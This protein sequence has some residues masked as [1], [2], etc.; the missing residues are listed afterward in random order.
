MAKSRAPAGSGTTAVMRP[1]PGGLTTIPPPPPPPP[2]VTVASLQHQVRDFV[3]EFT[4]DECF[5]ANPVKVAQAEINIEAFA[6][7]IA[8]FYDFDGAFL[9]A[10]GIEARIGARLIR[11]PQCPALRLV[12]AFPTATPARIRFD[13]PDRVIGP[14]QPFEI[15]IASAG[16]RNVTILMIDPDGRVS[17]LSGYATRFGTDIKVRMVVPLAG[18]RVLLVL[19]TVRPLQGTEILAPERLGDFF[20]MVLDENLARDFDIRASMTFFVIQ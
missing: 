20:S 2:A 1:P 10:I 4:G 16:L 14:A 11:S 3:A 12:R 8:P 7:D 19:D 13:D 15:S 6:D 17:D 9:A 18:P 5:L